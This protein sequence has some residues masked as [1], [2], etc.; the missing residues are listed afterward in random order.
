MALLVAHVLGDQAAPGGEREIRDIG[1]ARHEGTG[2]QATA[3]RVGDDPVAAP[4]HPVGAVPEE[5]SGSCRRGCAG[6]RLGDEGARSD[7]ALQVALDQQLVVGAHHGIAAQ[8][9]FGGQ[10][11]GRRHGRSALQPPVEDG[12]ADAQVE[13]RALARHHGL[14]SESLHDHFTSE[15]EIHR[16]ATQIGPTKLYQIGSTGNRFFRLA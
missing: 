11:A 7:P 10:H 4:R 15:F 13:P 5:P 9:Q 12:L 2:L 6:H 16:S 14:G 8:A 1:N 3:G